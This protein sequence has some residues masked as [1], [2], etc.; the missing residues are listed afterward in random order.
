MMSRSPVVERFSK[1]MVLR[2]L[3]SSVR[4]PFEPELLLFTHKDSSFQADCRTATSQTCD[5]IPKGHRQGELVRLA[6]GRK[7][8][9]TPSEHHFRDPAQSFAVG[10]RI[11]VSG[12]GH[13][14]PIGSS[15]KDL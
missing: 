11:G 14:I 5:G 2:I 6:T 15:I 12:V 1:W 8:G 4:C 10:P 7:V 3:F 9:P 13:P